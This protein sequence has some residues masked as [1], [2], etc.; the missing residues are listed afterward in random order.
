MISHFKEKGLLKARGKQR[1][2]STHILAAIKTLNRLELVAETMIHTLN[3]LATVA[4]EWLREWVPTEWFNRYE[5]RLDEY[6]LPQEKKERT[7]FAETIGAE[8][9]KAKPTLLLSSSRH[10]LFY[11]IA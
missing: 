1:T 8:K 10:G 3:V 7:L 5:K 11:R 2:D 4:P 6:R 9:V